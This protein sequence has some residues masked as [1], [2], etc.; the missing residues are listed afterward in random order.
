MH[1]S[2]EKTASIFMRS[3]W[4]ERPGRQRRGLRIGES[5]GQKVTRVHIFRAK[6]LLG[7]TDAR[8]TRSNYRAN[9]LIKKS[10]QL[11][12]LKTI[13]GPAGRP[14]WFAALAFAQKCPNHHLNDTTVVFIIMTMA[15]VINKIILPIIN[16]PSHGEIM[17]IMYGSLLVR[18]PLCIR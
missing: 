5:L 1:H 14:I 6:M 3:S 17:R 13:A 2:L 15:F 12:L 4:Q 11:L 8:A 16:M 18:C 7:I 10:H 9:S